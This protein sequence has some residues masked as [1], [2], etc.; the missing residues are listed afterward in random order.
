[1]QVEERG[2]R[3]LQLM[4]VWYPAWQLRH[5]AVPVCF[6]RSLQHQGGAQ[7]ACAAYNLQSTEL[8]SLQKGHENDVSSL[9]RYTFFTCTLLVFFLAIVVG[10]SR[11]L[12][13]PR[14]SRI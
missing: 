9:G 3:C 6:A 2:G 7:D 5:R 11:R 4:I 1:M 13:G 10:S 14:Q 12:I 8:S